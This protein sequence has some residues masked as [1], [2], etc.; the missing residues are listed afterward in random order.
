MEH[1]CQ[2]FL[3]ILRASES[4]CVRVCASQ[5]PCAA[6][7]IYMITHILTQGPDGRNIYAFL[8]TDKPKKAHRECSGLLKSV[9]KTQIKHHK[10]AKSYVS[11]QWLFIKLPILFLE[12]CF[13]GITDLKKKWAHKSILSKLIYNHAWASLIPSLRQ[14]IQLVLFMSSRSYRRLK[15]CQ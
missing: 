2:A 1:A 15:Q 14:G 10:Q 5:E 13:E 6:N 7:F 8:H 12:S 9:G 4:S 3:D 11:R